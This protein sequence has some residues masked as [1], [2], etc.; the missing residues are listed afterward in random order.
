MPRPPRPAAFSVS[1]DCSP[2]WRCSAFRLA[3]R[4]VLSWFAL[5]IEAAAHA[6]TS[7]TMKMVSTSMMA[8]NRL[9][10]CLLSSGR[11]QASGV[12][13]GSLP[14]WQGPWHSISDS[15]GCEEK[16]QDDGRYDD[17]QHIIE[18]HC[19]L[20]TFLAS[21]H[22]S[23]RNLMLRTQ[24]RWLWRS[25]LRLPVFQSSLALRS[26]VVFMLNPSQRYRPWSDDLCGA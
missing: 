19:V 14:C 12:G 20:P 13:H 7:R 25:M 21:N 8:M 18:S 9:E 3:G 15:D 24:A 1:L 6:S 16:S 26:M 22:L 11:W 10:V 4:A 23:P 2:V 5:R 17:E